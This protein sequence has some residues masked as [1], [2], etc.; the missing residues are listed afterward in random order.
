MPNSNLIASPISHDMFPHPMLEG[1][2]GEER[3]S[4]L[5][6]RRFLERYLN[7]RPTVTE[8]VFAYH[9]LERMQKAA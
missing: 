1:Y 9:V 3:Q 8:V 4:M 5:G 2:G 6:V 7:R